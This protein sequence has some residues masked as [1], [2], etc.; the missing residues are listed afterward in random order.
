MLHLQTQTVAY[1]EKFRVTDEDVEFIYNLL[2]EKET[3]L[4]QDEISLA[5][6][7]HRIRQE[8][9]S[10]ERQ[11]AKGEL[12]QPKNRYKVGQTLV[13]PA[14][15]YATGTIV[16]ER[17]GSNPEHGDFVV[18]EVEFANQRREFASDLQTPHPLNVNGD[19]IVDAATTLSPAEL[20]D[21]Y[22]DNLRL[23]LAQ[24]LEREEDIVSI[25]DR[26]FPRSLLIEVNVG[27]LNLAEAVL[28]L[29]GG[30]PLSSETLLKDAGLPDEVN[31]NLRI[32]S[33][34]YALQEDARFDEVGPAGK[35]MWYLRRLEPPEVLDPPA[36]LVYTPIEYNRSL[37]TAEMLVLE[38]DI[39]DEHSPLPDAPADTHEATITLIYPHRLAGT[40][41]LSAK[42]RPLFPT[43]YQA[44]RVR[45][46]L[47]DGQTGEEF[48]G[49]VVRKPRFVFGLMEYYR[50]YRIPVGAY[51]TLSQMDDPTRVMVTHAVRR[52]RTEWVRMAKVEGNRLVFD[53]QRRSIG[54]GYD[55]LMVISA[56]DLDAVEA[57]W[58][59]MNKGGR[60]LADLLRDLVPELAKLNPQ[61]TVHAKTLYS[62]VNVLR[63]CPP[64]PIFATLIER[65]E[66]DYVGDSYWRIN[67]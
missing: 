8:K 47:V 34:D 23:Q 64:G 59:E 18:I 21:R 49:W 60:R 30:G 62:G 51:I 1:W 4:F 15:N 56:D 41:P 32:F 48:P 19:D 52:P 24:R 28:D 14:F 33:L 9:E 44:E 26:W 7:E 50:K 66:F 27:N 63:R 45:M 31:K 37:L 39:D 43:A 22:G 53:I 29:A 16:S 25:A 12:F 54:A 13:F 11:L 65:P 2:L 3:P 20:L 55:D 6:V 5:L 40:L 61:G 42:L 36:R 58:L 35:V 10:F 57:L 38:D 17:P 67:R 46:I